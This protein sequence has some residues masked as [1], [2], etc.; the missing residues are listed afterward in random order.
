MNTSLFQRNKVL[1]IFT[2]VVI[3]I[4]DFTHRT[5][6]LTKLTPTRHH[7]PSTLTMAAELSSVD[8]RL[9]ALLV[10]SVIPVVWVVYPS[11][12]RSW[13]VTV[14][15]Q[16]VRAGGKL[17]ECWTTMVFWLANA[18]FTV[19]MPKTDDGEMVTSLRKMSHEDITLGRTEDPRLSTTSWT[20]QQSW[21]WKRTNSSMTDPG[22]KVS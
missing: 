10:D 20:Q 17:A 16:W 4:I 5:E 2:K 6:W 15:T 21:P 8:H 18:L 1:E 7:L 9:L 22:V 12:V 13:T 11:S 19:L 14:R 3:V